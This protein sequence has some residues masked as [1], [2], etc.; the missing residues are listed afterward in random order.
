[1]PHRRTKKKTSN[2]YKIARNAVKNYM[3]KR[4]EVKDCTHVISAASVSTSGNIL[5]LW[6]PSVLAVGTAGDQRIGNQVNILNAQMRVMISQADTPYNR[7]RYMVI[8]CRAR[9]GASL[10]PI[11]NATSYSAFGGIF[12]SFNYNF[13]KRVYL[14]KTVMLQEK[15]DGTLRTTFRK[16]YLKNLKSKLHWQNETSSP[17][18]LF[19]FIAVSDS[20][21]P[22][23]PQITL[24][25]TSRFQDL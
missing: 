18:E 2:S 12:S 9:L 20:S 10:A 23:H 6:G 13:V 15:V 1:M 17:Q 5:P 22:S 3:N 19:Y 7:V 14:D 4:C 24:N 11:F 21:A 16:H 25:L 8:S